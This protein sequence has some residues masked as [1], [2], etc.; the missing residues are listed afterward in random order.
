[1]AIFTVVFLPKM[2]MKTPFLNL[3]I[4]HGCIDFDM[5]KPAKGL[6][7]SESCGWTLFN[8][9]AGVRAIKTEQREYVRTYKRQR[10]RCGFFLFCRHQL[11]VPALAPKNSKSSVLKF[12]ESKNSV[13]FF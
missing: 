11:G 8:V 2:R 10:P 5:K 12:F 6:N 13:L 4:I 9:L 3:Q 7:G 1:M